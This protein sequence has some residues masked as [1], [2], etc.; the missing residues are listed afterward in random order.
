[1][2]EK[3]LNSRMIQKHDI[4]ENW[5]KAVNFI[6]KQGEIIIYD[7]DN[8][9]DYER[10][11]VGDG[12]TTVSALPFSNEILLE[13]DIN[14]VLNMENL[15]SENLPVTEYVR[16]T[17]QTLTEAEKKQA[18]DNIDAIDAIK[19]T[20]IVQEIS[21]DSQD[22]TKL[23]NRVE[24]LTEKILSPVDT[25]KV[26]WELGNL[27]NDT[28]TNIGVENITR[29]R[30]VGK[31]QLPEKAV[32]SCEAGYKIN[33]FM[34]STMNDNSYIG[35]S[36]MT[37][38][39]YI[40]TTD[41]WV[42]LVACYED[43]REITNVDL[44]SDAVN[45]EAYT[46]MAMT[47]EDV[48]EMLPD[49]FGE[50]DISSWEWE[51]GNIANSGSSTEG[52]VATSTTRI[53]TTNFHFL[54]AGT[55]FSCLP[56]YIY[57]VFMYS[58]D[59]EGSYVKRSTVIST[60]YTLDDDYYVKVAMGHS[61]GSTITDIVQVKNSLNLVTPKYTT[62]EQVKARIETNAFPVI[63]SPSIY[64]SD[65]VEG[66]D[67][68]NTTVQ[69][70]Y[71]RYDAL[72][73]TYPQWI[74]RTED[75]GIDAA[76]NPIRKYEVRLQTPV[77][78]YNA[79]WAP[80]GNGSYTN[81]WQ[82]VIKYRRALLNAGTHG[83]ERTACW[84]LLYWIEELVASNEP[85]ALYIKGNFALDIIPVFN[86]DGYNANR[87]TNANGVD[88]NRNYD[89]DTHEPEVQAM[90]NYLESIKDELHCACDCH[91]ANGDRGFLSV[92]ISSPIM[93]SMMQLANQIFGVCLTSWDEMAAQIGLSTSVR[94]YMY[95]C[96]ATN[97]GTFPHYLL[98]QGLTPY[99]Y[100]V[101]TTRPEGVKMGNVTK[102]IKDCLGN[103]IPA[104][105]NM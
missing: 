97:V 86:P 20:E 65:L 57:N 16:Y 94:P 24:L 40:L 45:I 46:S 34:F 36:T 38:E 68:S 1:M 71:D 8:N 32:I 49:A 70:V 63:G 35:R 61:S 104:F 93:P 75:L 23:N 73:T 66:A 96:M 12:T 9:Y 13:E 74:S 4:E 44:V 30:T 95:A 31:I 51:M 11:K 62:D 59:F 5:E 25:S 47:R 69:N 39:P 42:R 37:T 58:T 26:T 77:V 53:R 82:S 67:Y 43:D 90:I 3:I 85:W 92:P 89:D 29:I 98:T 27:G 14:E 79:D 105:L 91:T 81:H 60:S 7:I 88:L 50:V 84:G 33:V 100:T 83:N 54:Q 2:A 56:E 41:A 19:V 103:A 52:S 64:L 15:T 78:G 72:C 21:T 17:V 48:E 76:G 87:R 102:I 10:I 6:P 18:R 101:E 80:S 55:R 28:G 22:Y 99:A